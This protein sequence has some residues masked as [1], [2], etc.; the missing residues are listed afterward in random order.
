MSI[1]VTIVGVHNNIPVALEVNASG[2]LC[3]SESA[4]N[5]P[6]IDT[7][8]GFGEVLLMGV[9]RNTPTPI[10]VNDNGELII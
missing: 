1:K 7:S 4:N 8:G 5:K 3:T 6:A 2:Q 9:Y 10:L